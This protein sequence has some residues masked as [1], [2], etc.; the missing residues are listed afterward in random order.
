[1]NKILDVYHGLYAK[2][3]PQN[4]WPVTK[5]GEIAP[6]YHKNINLTEKQQLEVCFGAILTQNTNW[7]NVEKAIFELNKI[8]FIKNYPQYLVGLKIIFCSTVGVMESA[9]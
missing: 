8:S 9:L 2:F 3:G 7:K 4:W 6:K 1:M 5:E